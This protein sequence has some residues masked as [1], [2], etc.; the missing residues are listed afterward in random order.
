MAI[1][2]TYKFFRGKK[3]YNWHYVLN[4]KIHRLKRGGEYDVHPSTFRNAAYNAATR[5][6]LKIRSRI[7]DNDTIVIQ[8]YKPCRHVAKANR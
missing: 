5:W 2:N 8:A 6:G 3:C 4:G 1:L 7:E